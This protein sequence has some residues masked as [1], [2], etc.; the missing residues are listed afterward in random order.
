[1]DILFQ[2]FSAY[3]P[4]LWL[5]LFVVTAILLVWLLAL[6]AKVGRLTN[7]YR[8]LLPSGR[9]NLDE[10]LERQLDKLKQTD[11][12]MDRL[13]EAVKAAEATSLR[14]LQHVGI[15]RFNPFDDTGGDQS[16]CIAVLDGDQNGLVLTSIFTRTQCRVYAKPIENGGSR[17]QLSVEETEAVKL[18]ANGKSRSLV[19]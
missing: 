15:V 13:M 8:R 14:A 9:G 19:P 16:F 4:F 3:G 12:R 2:L 7:H 18:A 5:A 6:Q 17:Y 1:M 11:E 10:V